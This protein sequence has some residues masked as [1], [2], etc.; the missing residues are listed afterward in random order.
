MI[1]P[2][3]THVL[4]NSNT[5]NMSLNEPVTFLTEEHIWNYIMILFAMGLNQQPSIACY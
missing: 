4:I 2:L 1:Q 3:I 5:Y